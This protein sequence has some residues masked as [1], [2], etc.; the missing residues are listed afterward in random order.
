MKL[1]DIT[2]DLSIKTARKPEVKG[3]GMY[4]FAMEDGTDRHCP[5]ELWD[6]MLGPKPP[7]QWPGCNGCSFAP[8][9][10]REG[11]I[12]WP[13][14]RIHDW[15]YCDESPHVLQ[16]T[17]DTTLRLNVWRIL[18]AQGVSM[19]DASLV[20]ASYFGG[21]TVGGRPHYRRKR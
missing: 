7:H 10:A 8:D 21:V 3:L 2:P 6:V 18:R 17:A 1:S 4:R 19:V 5:A 9:Y 15:H 14:C 11:K 13:A 12:I 20:A 16:H